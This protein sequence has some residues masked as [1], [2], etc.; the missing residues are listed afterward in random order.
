M[1]HYVSCLSRMSTGKA[2]LL[3]SVLFLQTQAYAGASTNAPQNKPQAKPESNQQKVPDSIGEDPGPVYNQMVLQWAK[4]TNFAQN[5][6]EVIV[7]K[8][9]QEMENDPK[10]KQVVTKEMLAD[11]EQFFYELFLSPETISQLSILYS[12]YFTLDDMNDLIKFYQSPVGAKFIKADPELKLKTQRI[13]EILLKKHE[14]QYMAIVWKY[15][16]KNNEKT[17]EKAKTD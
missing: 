8:F 4:T 3:V 15:L 16:P 11:L 13:G 12:Q 1:K 6:A 17:N 5:A 2:L 14:K 10:M 7:G 9:K